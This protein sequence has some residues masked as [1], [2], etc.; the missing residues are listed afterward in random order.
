MPR[1]PTKSQIQAENDSLKKQLAEAAGAFE[2][3]EGAAEEMSSKLD[4][5]RKKRTEMDQ[6]HRETMSDLEKMTANFNEL[7]RELADTKKALESAEEE[8][9]QKTNTT[10]PQDVKP[11]SEMKFYTKYSDFMENALD[12][13][14]NGKRAVHGGAAAAGTWAAGTYGGIEVISQNMPVAMGV[15]AAVGFLGTVALD[16]MVITPEEEAKLVRSRAMRQEKKTLALL[17]EQIPDMM[18]DL[19]KKAS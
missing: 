3:L 10:P 11:M 19:Q 5:S 13:G 1:P 17:A 6:A 7:K 4:A 16:K 12:L 15:G 14:R 18:A 9:N 8:I 2:E